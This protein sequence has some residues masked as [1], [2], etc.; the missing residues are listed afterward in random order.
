M[1][2]NRRNFMA[3]IAPLAMAPAALAANGDDS[4]ADDRQYLEWIRYT[5]P[6]RRDKRVEKYYEEAAIP[7]LNRLGI[8]DVGVFSVMYGPNDPSLY[9]LIPHD[10]ID[11]L[12]TGQKKL[13]EDE[14]YQAAAKE[15]LE[16]SISDPAFARVE[17]GL[18]RAFSGM[19]KVEPPK[20][21]LSGKRIFEL[22]IYESHN[23]FKAQ[24]KIE[25]FN[26]AG[27]IQVFRDAGLTPVFFGETLFGPLMPNLTYMLV[28]ENMAERDKHWEKFRTSEGWA[29][30]KDL[31]EYKDTVSNIT[32]IILRPARCSQI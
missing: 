21:M 17:R 18:M 1:S 16:S 22:R 23:Q 7:A 3:G 24:K 12:M 9:V 32:D 29:A 8:H 13:L 19:P 4:D 31:E 11:S 15:Y 26:D 6:G 25:M 5:L 27:E 10:S 20:E 28:F 2:M 14:F 30:I